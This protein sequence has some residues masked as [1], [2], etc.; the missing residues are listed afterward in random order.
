V[1]DAILMDHITVSDKAQFQLCGEV[2]KQNH[3][4]A[5][6][7]C[8]L[9]RKPLQSEKGIWFSLMYPAEKVKYVHTVYS[10]AIASIWKAQ[11]SMCTV[12]RLVLLLCI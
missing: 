11:V 12:C 7:P 3:R 8:L 10:H 2:N 6:N 4:S 5:A 9:H 1:A